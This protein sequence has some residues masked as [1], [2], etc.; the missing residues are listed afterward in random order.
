MS[1]S[2]ESDNVIDD[3]S[4]DPDEEMEEEDSDDEGDDVEEDG[5]SEFNPEIIKRSKEIEE[6]AKLE[7]ARIKFIFDIK[8]YSE[9]GPVR[10]L[11]KRANDFW[12][13]VKELIDEYI[14]SSEKDMKKIAKK[15]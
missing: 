10:K 15:Q 13:S 3:P 1:M 7:Q 2:E 11:H 9:D 12:G 8:D 5:R 4:F 14:E 6:F